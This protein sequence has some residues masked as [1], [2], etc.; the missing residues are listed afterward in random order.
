MSF[1]IFLDEDNEVEYRLIKNKTLNG[2]LCPEETYA[3]YFIHIIDEEESVNEEEIIK[4]LKEV[5]IILT[6][7]KVDV[8]K[9]KSKTNLMF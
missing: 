9:L 7:F 4:K 3:D 5:N 2:S 6:A 1:F 8:S